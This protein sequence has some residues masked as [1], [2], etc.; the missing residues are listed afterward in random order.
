[1]EIYEPLLLTPN[2][3]IV[4]IQL[5][6]LDSKTGEA[7]HDSGLMNVALAI[8]KDNPV[9]PIGLKL[10]L[11]SLAAGSY[12]AEMKAVDSAGHSSVPR[13]VDFEVQ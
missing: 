6:V 8:R 9:I 12:R 10:P 7:K 13:T 2:Q 4:G 3:P 1:V 11:D 5:R